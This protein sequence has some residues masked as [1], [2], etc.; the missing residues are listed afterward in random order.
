MKRSTKLLIVSAVLVLLYP[1]QVFLAHISCNQQREWAGIQSKRCSAMGE[2]LYHYHERLHVYPGHLHNLVD[3]GLVT[4][5]RYRELMFQQ[6]P[7]ATPSEWRYHVP[8]PPSS[9]FLFSGKSVTTWNCPIS[10]YVIGG[11][12]GSTLVFG[13]EKLST[14]RRDIC[15][16]TEFT[17]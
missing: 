17:E 5:A 7:G 6:K 14:L 11:A 15:Q 1:G 13:N 9:F 10:S 2:L 16:F 3:S 4:E 12:D 8:S